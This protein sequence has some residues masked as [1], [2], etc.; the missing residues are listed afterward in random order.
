[1]IREVFR[2]RKGQL[3]TYKVDELNNTT[4]I[5]DINK[6]LKNQLVRG[7]TT[8]SE[9]LPS[10]LEIIQKEPYPLYIDTNTNELYTS[11]DNGVVEKVSKTDYVTSVTNEVERNILKNKVDSI[12]TSDIDLEEKIKELLKKMPTHVSL[13][14]NCATCGATLN[15]EEN[16][17]VFHCKYCGSTY[18]IGPAQIY[19]HY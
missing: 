16:K 7:I 12:T 8:E 11:Y 19:S 4:D 3:D 2:N 18:V 14:H 15:I 17:P 10:T 13:V 6:V 9:M 5:L 1:M